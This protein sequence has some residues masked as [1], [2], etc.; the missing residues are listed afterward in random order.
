ME[1]DRN[2]TD[3]V[4]FF[5]C[6]MVA[7]HH[8]SQYVISNNISHNLL[9]QGFSS[10]GGY[11]G[12]AVFFF[13]SGY[14]LMKS[15]MI[16]HLSFGSFVRK[17]FMKVYL[18][19]VLV[20]AIWLPIYYTLVGKGNLSVSVIDILQDLLWNWKDGVLWFIRCLLQ[21]YIAFALYSVLRLYFESSLIR[22][23]LL[24]IL[25][26]LMFCLQY[27]TVADYSSISV[28][29]FFLGICVAEFKKIKVY[30]TNKWISTGVML[31]IIALAWI[32]R[33]KTL[34][35]HACFNYLFILLWMMFAARKTIRFK[36]VPK[37][38]ATMSFDVYLVHMKCL[39]VLKWL[40]VIPLYYFAGCTVITAV[41]FGR[42]RAIFRI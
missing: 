4:K 19:V 25:A 33:H 12:V 10:Q 24:S 2:F 37:W 29:L 8:Y 18:P 31:L 27:F 17:R 32:L 39:I 7:V 20:T 15:D 30:L 41:V 6:I 36:A 22:I 3:W 42:L 5:S 9:Y 11:L 40:P 34:F 16:K 13:L 28:P 38:M 1:L 23:F 26:T 35:V 21:L 14:G